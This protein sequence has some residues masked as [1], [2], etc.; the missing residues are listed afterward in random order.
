MDQRLPFLKPKETGPKFLGGK[1]SKQTNKNHQKTI[2]DENTFHLL[3]QGML[4]DVPPFSFPQAYC[5]LCFL[6]GGQ[7]CWPSHGLFS[8]GVQQCLQAILHPP[9]HHAGESPPRRFRG[10]GAPPLALVWVVLGLLPWTVCSGTIWRQIK[11]FSLAHLG[12]PELTQSAACQPVVRSQEVALAIGRG[13]SFG[14]VFLLSLS[15]IVLSCC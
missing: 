2:Y 7:C 10:E 3:P 14:F 11:G 5:V 9:H 4:G 15:G 8:Q 1:K 6:A 13:G 12:D